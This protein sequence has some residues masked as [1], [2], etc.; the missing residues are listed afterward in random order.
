M[1]AKVGRLDGKVSIITGGAGS[2]GLAQLFLSEGAKDGTEFF[3]DIISLRRHGKP[4]EIARSVLFLASEES[5]F[6]TG[7]MLAADGGMSA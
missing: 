1:D 5:S 3:N 6:M 4:G 2:V 7:A